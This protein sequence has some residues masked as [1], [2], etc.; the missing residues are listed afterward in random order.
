METWHPPP[1][2]QQRGLY[3]SQSVATRPVGRRRLVTKIFQVSSV[4]GMFFD[5]RRCS[6]CDVG[7]AMEGL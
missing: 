7:K 1:R 6:A 2:A 4:R 3:S 5:I